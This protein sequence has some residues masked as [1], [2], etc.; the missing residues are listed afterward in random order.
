MPTVLIPPEKWAAIQRDHAMGILTIPEISTKHG[1]KVTTIT[2][3]AH[4]EQWKRDLTHRVAERTAEKLFKASVDADGEAPREVARHKRALD[5]Q[6]ESETIEA[7]AE[8]HARIVMQHRTRIGKASSLCNGL[9]DELALQSMSKED[10]QHIAELHSMIEGQ[11]DDIEA[12]PEKVQARVNAWKKLLS[13]GNRADVL[14]KL[15]DALRQ[16]TLLERSVYGISDNANGEAEAKAKAAA[17]QAAQTDLSINEV[18]RRVAFTL[19]MG[20][21]AKEKAKDIKPIEPMEH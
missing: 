9:M 2:A 12:S 1:V 13:L 19:H 3:R 5:R 11:G 6:A 17:E 21:K 20:M 18:A 14:K 8:M 16:L 10:L 15:A 4:R 7:A